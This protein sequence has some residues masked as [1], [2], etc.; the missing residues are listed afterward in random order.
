MKLKSFGCSFIFGSDLQD[1]IMSGHREPSD[2]TWPA[3][4]AR[5]LGLDYE[6]YARPGEGNFLIFSNVMNQASMDDPSIFVINWT[7]IDRFDFVD[8]VGNWE[9]I[10]PGA[11]SKTAQFYYRHLHSQYKDVLSSVYHIYSAILFL[12]ERKIP[13]VMTN[14][15]YLV[16]EP[17][18]PN[19][20]DPNKY[21]SLIQRKIKP[22]LNDF[23]HK[24]F[25]DWS[26]AHNFEV[27]PTWH[28]L[29]NAHA[30]AA[31]FMIPAIDAILHRA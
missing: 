20:H 27:S 29:E 7:W 26:R 3:L 23:D 18:D 22:F 5:S 30:A 19:W 4:A 12:A 14:M 24:N 6:C 13:F 8:S 31:E 2:F 16:L 11:N 28:P 10:T 1:T 25:L 15:D 21:L 9:T 17:I